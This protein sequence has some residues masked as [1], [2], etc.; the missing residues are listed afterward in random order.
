MENVLIKTGDIPGVTVRDGSPFYDLCGRSFPVVGVL[1]DR[2]GGLVPV[3]DF[4][5]MDDRQWN[6]LA[7]MKAG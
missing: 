6:D 2:N 5:W 7:G 1:K 4:K 3:L